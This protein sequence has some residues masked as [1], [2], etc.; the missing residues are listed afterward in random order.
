MWL[1]YGLFL[2]Q[3]QEYAG[4]FAAFERAKALAVD[5]PEVFMSTIYQI[6]R[7]AAVLSMT[8]IEQGIAAL[9]LYEQRYDGPNEYPEIE[10]ALARRAQLHQLNADQKQFEQYIEKAAK[11]TNQDLHDLLKTL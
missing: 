11:S 10:W 3:K 5:G 2:Q 4:V 1:Q 9:S 6:G 7:S 8:N